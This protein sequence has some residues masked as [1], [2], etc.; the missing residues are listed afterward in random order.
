M[1][2]VLFV[3]GCVREESRTERLARKLLE[4]L[5]G[6]VEEVVLETEGIQPL[7]RD[8]LRERSNCIENGAMGAVILRYARQFAQADEIVIAAPYW[9][10][11]FPAIVK[12]YL[13]AVTV[14]GITFCY[15]EEGYPSGLCKAKKLYYV[16]TAGG[17]ILQW[18]MGYDYIKALSKLY[19]GIEETVCLTAENLDIVGADVEQIMVQAEKRCVG[20]DFLKM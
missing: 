4:Q 3:N 8:T 16:T 13:E 19:Y 18:N 1:N 17:P 15:T 10:L 14:N 7:N 11:S 12:N 20:I 2:R 9:D 6:E 5:S